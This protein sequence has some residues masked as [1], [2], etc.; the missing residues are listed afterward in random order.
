MANDE[1]F[2][3]AQLRVKSCVA[4]ST[5]DKA[6][7][8]ALAMPSDSAFDN[9]FEAI[10]SRTILNDSKNEIDIKI[11]DFNERLVDS[12]LIFKKK[13]PSHKR[14]DY[15]WLLGHDAIVDAKNSSWLSLARVVIKRRSGMGCWATIGF[16][17]FCNSK[18]LQAPRVFSKPKSR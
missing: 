12:L 4:N 11:S 15:A 10:D 6:V 14:K 2:I 9:R 7:D 17:Q 18:V 13:E 1:V 8:Y 5:L 16:A 3:C